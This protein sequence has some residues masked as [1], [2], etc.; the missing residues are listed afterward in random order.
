MI[1]FNLAMY[2]IR[3]GPVSVCKDLPSRS[4]FFLSFFFLLFGAALA[5]CGGS[6]ARGLIGAIAAGLH[7]SHSNMGSEPNLRPTLWLKTTPDP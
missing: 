5:A 7:H 4:F 2:L 3:D 1:F 6:Q